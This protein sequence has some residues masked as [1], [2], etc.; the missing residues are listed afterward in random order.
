[1]QLSQDTE[2]LVDASKV[3]ALEVNVERATS[4]LVSGHHNADQNPDLKRASKTF[5]NV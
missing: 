1:M 3:V 5:E 2:S 4:M